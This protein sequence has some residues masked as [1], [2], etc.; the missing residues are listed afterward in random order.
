MHHT[1]SQKSSQDM[2]SWAS[3]STHAHRDCRRPCSSPTIFLPTVPAFPSLSPMTPRLVSMGVPK[4]RAQSISS[5][6]LRLATHFRRRCEARLHATWANL[7]RMPSSRTDPTPLEDILESAYTI[8]CHEY[9]LTVTQ[10]VWETL[11]EKYGLRGALTGSRPVAKVATARS[12]HL[13]SA[14]PRVRARIRE[15]CATHL[16]AAAS[17]SVTGRKVRHRGLRGIEHAE[18]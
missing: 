12:K 4:D 17:G 3:S 6:M 2:T 13:H 18:A 14:P 9:T 10:W 16:S 11:K 7:A 1:I 15:H 8:H 5:E